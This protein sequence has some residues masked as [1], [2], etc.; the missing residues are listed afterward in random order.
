M[1]LSCLNI[2]VKFLKREVVETLAELGAILPKMTYHNSI[3]E[4]LFKMFI[5]GG[6]VSKSKID[7]IFEESLKKVVRKRSKGPAENYDITFLEGYLTC[8]KMEAGILST[9]TPLCKMV[10]VYANVSKKTR[11]VD[12][13]ANRP[14]LAVE[15]IMGRISHEQLHKRDVV[16]YRLHREKQRKNHVLFLSNLVKEAQCI[17][18]SEH[19][20]LVTR[21]T[22]GGDDTLQ[23]RTLKLQMRIFTHNWKGNK[24]WAKTESQLDHL[25]PKTRMKR[26]WNV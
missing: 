8:V 18:K 21:T 10:L 25:A 12:F 16:R 1:T 5:M 17:D 2:N 23:D 6:W 20:Y 26:S 14:G 7:Y 3:D 22:T 13:I 4:A 19:A 11:Y 15:H 9:E 24:N